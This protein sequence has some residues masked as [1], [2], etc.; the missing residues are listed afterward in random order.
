MERLNRRISNRYLRHLLQAIEEEMGRQSLRM[1][2]RQ[3]GLERYVPELPENNHETVSF[4]SEIAAL[5]AGIRAY[6]GHGA[7]GSLNRI[8]RATWRR[9]LEEAPFTQR[10]RLLYARL[11]P[12]PNR[13]MKLLQELLQEMSEGGGVCSVHLVDPDLVLVDESSDFTFAQTED[14]KICWVTQGML[15]EILQWGSTQEF[16]VEEISCRATGAE[17]CKFQIRPI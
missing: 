14:T 2:L 12:E 17:V 4:A 16:D 3:T 11:L 13:A 1:V 5:Q 7:R 15:E 8:G 9:M 6:Y 10:L